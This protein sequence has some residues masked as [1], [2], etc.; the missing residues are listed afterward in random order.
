MLNNIH[1]V[2]E[3]VHPIITTPEGST[4]AVLQPV[5]TS[6][7]E[8]VY[9]NTFPA[10][11]PRTD[12]CKITDYEIPPTDDEDFS[13][14]IYDFSDSKSSDSIHI[15][16]RDHVN[17]L[18]LTINDLVNIRSCEGELKG[19]IHKCDHCRNNKPLFR[20][21]PGTKN[22]YIHSKITFNRVT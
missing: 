3:D 14:E 12:P 9:E 8:S 15:K 7:V 19:K 18:F 11:A 13:E 17:I 20:Q 16:L 2:N 22:F 6:E 21:I 1:S 4:L 10:A 5:P